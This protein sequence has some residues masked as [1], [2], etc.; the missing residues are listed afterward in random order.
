MAADDGI[1]SAAGGS[2]VPWGRARGLWRSTRWARSRRRGRRP[3]AGRARTR[4]VG[5]REHFGRIFR[6]PA[7]AQQTPKVEAAL[8]ELGRPGGLLDADD[9]LA[10]G[11]EGAD[12]RPVAERE[13][14]EQ[15]EPHGGD[16]V[17]RPVPRPRHDLRR[18]RSR[19]ARPTN[20]QSARNFRTPALDLDSVYGAGPGRAAGAL[21][22]CRPRQAQG[23]E[24]RRCSR[25]CR[26][27]RTAPRSSATR[28]TTST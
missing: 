8:R 14:P 16:D 26:A 7:F 17:L 24:R 9:P 11:P 20:P 28:A 25:T 19:L 6:L 10:A 2:W 12:R 5:R 21:R 3:R 15:P 22:P 13:Q 27:A 18:R 1:V 23:R 4:R